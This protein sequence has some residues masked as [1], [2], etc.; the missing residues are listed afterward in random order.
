MTYY[1]AINVPTDTAGFVEVINSD[2]TYY[3]QADCGSECGG[4]DE[5]SAS[6]N[7]S[8]SPWATLTRAFNFLE[9]KRIA[10][11]VT[12]TLQVLNTEGMTGWNQYLINESQIDIRHPNADRIVIKGSDTRS[13]NLFGINYYDSAFRGMQDSVTGGYLMEL[14]VADDELTNVSVGD[15]ITITDSNYSSTSHYVTGSSGPTFLE[16]DFYNYSSGHTAGL[17]ISGNSYDASPLSLRKTLALG[18]HEI[19]GIDTATGYSN[20]TLL[21][22]VRHTNPTYSYI[23]DL[24]DFL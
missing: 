15:F 10:N 16:S 6:Q 5:R 22:H 12:V 14:T 24:F 21:V 20:Q 13:L 8:A 9:D 18:C 19:L 11:D 2:S 23:V 7:N 17:D 1:S 3:I 4:N